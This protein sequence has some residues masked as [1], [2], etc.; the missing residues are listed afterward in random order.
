MAEW[1]GPITLAVS[2]VGEAT[3]H[4]LTPTA[5]ALD[6]GVEFDHNGERQCGDCGVW[7]DRETVG[8]VVRC[9][10]PREWCSV[11]CPECADASIAEAKEEVTP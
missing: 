10:T 9:D 11:L 7:L 6:Y 1:F 8:C 3:Y 4:Y 5:A 2:Q